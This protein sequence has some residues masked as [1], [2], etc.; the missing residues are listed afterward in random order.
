MSGGLADLN[1]A[2]RV[3][4]GVLVTLVLA[5]LAGCAS[6][7]HSATPSR[8]PVK[9]RPSAA[10]GSPGTAVTTQS[11]GLARSGAQNLVASSTLKAALLAAFAA[12]KGLPTGDVTGPLP[13][14]LYYG[15][16]GS[17]TYWAVADFS[18]ASSAP[19]PAKVSMQDGG[20]IGVFSHQGGQAWAVHTGGEPFP[21]P[22]ELPADL[23]AVW[24]LKSSG[25]CDML[26]ATSP[27]KAQ[28]PAAIVQYLPGGTYFGTVLYEDLEL[29]GTGNILFQPDTWQ[30][31]SSP[32]SQGHG[33]YTLNF[34]PSTV[35][36]YWTGTSRSSSHEVLGSYDLA[37]AQRVQSAMV[38]FMTQ[39]DS[40]Y[41]VTVSVPPGCS[42]VC[43]AVAKIIQ[44][45]SVAP[46]PANP[47]FTAPS[48]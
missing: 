28:A 36:G 41:E 27:A 1:R 23:M 37:F 42:G 31:A 14:T 26:N 29:D 40:G 20:N 2:R 19:L 39:P 16:S 7:T 9:P 17:G 8:D 45:N 22:G 33:F 46:L 47:D 48:Q 18:P 30:G 25:W 24:G 38:P 44:I 11:A 10:H 32:S 5:G 15:I 21:C 3:W 34:D 43:A 4:L 35:A 13:G 12:E 6:S